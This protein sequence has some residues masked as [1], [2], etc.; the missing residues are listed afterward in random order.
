MIR[1]IIAF[2]LFSLLITSCATHISKPKSP[3]QNTKVKFSEFKRVELKQVELNENYASRS[4]KAAAERVDRNLYKNMMEAF[5]NT[6]RI[7]KGEEFSKTR[8][9]TLQI[10]PIIEEVKY[11][12]FIP[13]FFIAF[14]PGSSAILMRVEFR[15]SATGKIIADPEFYRKGNTFLGWIT[16]GAMDK[17]TLSQTTRNIVK[18]YKD[19]R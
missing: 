12:G 8:E 9:R 10:T 17:I 1:K 15:D 3:P 2:S 7:A 16:L 13:R 11:V 5:P 6:H 19:N 18:Y 14:I 4:G